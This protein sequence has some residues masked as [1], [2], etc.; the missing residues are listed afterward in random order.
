MRKIQQGFTLIELMIVVAIIGI[1]AAI[2]LPAYTDYTIRSKVS[3]LLVSAGN[4]RTCITE[5][6]Q[7]SGAGAAVALTANDITACTPAVVGK[8]TAS[9][10]SAAGVVTVSGTTAATSVG[11]AVTLTLTPTVNAAAGT[12]T[13]TCT[14]NAPKYSPA[15]CRGT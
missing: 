11:A 7:S 13:W 1:L 9:S 5:A 6:Y 8:V 14:S 4:A 15:S 2:A 12:L 3:E 10:V